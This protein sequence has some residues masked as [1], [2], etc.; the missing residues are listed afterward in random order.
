MKKIVKYSLDAALAVILFFIA[1]IF[2]LSLLGIKP[3]IVLSG[4]ME[5]TIP[6]GSLCFVDTGADYARLEEGEIIAYETG[7]GLLV[8]HRV[9][10]ITAEGIETGGDANAVSDGIVVTEENYYG[11]T[12]FWIPVAG[13]VLQWMQL[14]LTWLLGLGLAVV[15]GAGIR[16]ALQKPRSADIE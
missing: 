12:R 2:L 14:H 8:T 16:E 1:L 9:I 5:P 6:V 13:Y 11:K 3:Y 4:S 10:S 15:A 7:S